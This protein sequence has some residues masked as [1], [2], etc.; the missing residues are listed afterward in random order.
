M[1]V[2]L[3]ANVVFSAANVE[4]NIAELVDLVIRDHTAVTCNFALEEARRNVRLKR[5]AWAKGLTVLI[6]RLEL[7]HS[8]LFDLP[9]ELDE[10]DRPILCAAIRSG[11]DMLATGDRR[12][13]GHLYEQKIEGL[14]VVSVFGLAER[15]TRPAS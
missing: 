8:V 1:R 5:P 10:K 7:A 11:C 6:A 12:H 2:F 15:I 9:V 14:T 3:D 4:S 13:F